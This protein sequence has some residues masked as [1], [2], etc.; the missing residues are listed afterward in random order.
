MDAFIRHRRRL[1]GIGLACATGAVGIG[2]FY[3]AAAGA[4]ARLIGMNLA[5]YFVGLA[6]FATIVMPHWRIEGLRRWVLPGLGLVLLVTALTAAPVEGAAR[7]VAFGPLTLQVSLIVLPL[8]LVLFARRPTPGGAA[9]LV[10]AALALALQPDRAMAGALAAGLAALA[11]FRRDRLILIP[12]AAAAAGFA[13]TLARPDRLPAVPFVD[14][15]FYSS[16]GI[17]PLAGVALIFGAALLIV[18]ALAAFRAGMDRRAASSF[19]ALWL[20]IIIAAALGNYPTPLVG[21]GGSAIVG[22]LLSLAVLTPAR[23]SATAA[24]PA[25]APA[26]TD[27]QSSLS[28]SLA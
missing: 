22:Y 25:A 26:A 14:Q 23:A 1:R 17:H 20:T 24:R 21:Y 3:L 5:A 19:A 9:G 16:F 15:I 6:A 4:P 2:L 12:L 8:M 28:V 11:V 27:D 10:V 7:W 13:A 18:P